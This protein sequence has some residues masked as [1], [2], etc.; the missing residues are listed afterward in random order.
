MAA[1]AG[2]WF[3][4]VGKTLKPLTRPVHIITCLIQ[5]GRDL[6]R[7]LYYLFSVFEAPSVDPD[8]S[9]AR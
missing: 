2:T 9:A 8:P 6:F 5:G 4:Q 7:G 3:Q 1:P